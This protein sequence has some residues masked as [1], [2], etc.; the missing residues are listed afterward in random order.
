MIRKVVG[1]YYSPAGG[2]ARM[3]ERL[4]DEIAARLSEAC[5]EKIV[6]EC[7]SIKKAD[8]SDLG[9]ESLVIIAVPVYVG[10]APVSAV[11]ALKKLDG[12][13]AV[14]LT[15]VSY[16]GRS[17]GN[18][19]YEVSHYAEQRCFEVIGA[20]AI[21]ISYGSRLRK[22]ADR[23][24]KMDTKSLSDYAKAASAKILRLGGCDIDGLRVKAAPLEVD[25]R[26][27]VHRIS[28]IMPSAAALAQGILDSIPI[29]RKESQWFL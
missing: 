5:P 13:E 6:S 20:G 1:L 2:T 25:G 19:L 12:C 29:R 7:K 21:A 11:R 23:T 24:F 27:P 10:K 3:T 28:K 9:R 17:F 8:A 4:A 22:D 14:T 15:L 16:S 18:A 26:L